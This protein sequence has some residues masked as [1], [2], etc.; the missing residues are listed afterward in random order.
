MFW[1]LN[2]SVNMSLT[3]NDCNKVKVTKADRAGLNQA[4]DEAFVSTVH[5]EMLQAESR[6]HRSVSDP[7]Q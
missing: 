7:S 3:V 5:P 1:P 4:A 6:G 2:S